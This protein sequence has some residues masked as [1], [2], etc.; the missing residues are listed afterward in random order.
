MGSITRPT[1][2]LPRSLHARFVA[3]DAIR[4]G[5]PHSCPCLPTSA[6]TTRASARKAARCTPSPAC[7]PACQAA[8]AARSRW[9]SGNGSSTGAAARGAPRS[10]RRKPRRSATAGAAGAARPNRRA[11]SSARITPSIS[12]RSASYAATTSSIR[13][14]MPPARIAPVMRRKLMPRSSTRVPLGTCR[15]AVTRTSSSCSASRSG[16]NVD[17]LGDVEAGEV[18]QLEDVVDAGRDVLG[19]EHRRQRQQL[20]RDLR[21]QA[22]VPGAEGR[23]RR[24]HR[25]RRRVG[26]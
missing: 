2:S 15:S 20:A 26:A 17:E 12:R 24:V 13:G 7:A 18:V 6:P 19:P 22:R 23:R 3:T 10:R 8:I 21:L 5:V 9:P 4:S 16:R 14:A 11:S 1:S 25:F